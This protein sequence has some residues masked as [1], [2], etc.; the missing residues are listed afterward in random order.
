MTG[1]SSELH[2]Q[3]TREREIE[4]EIELHGMMINHLGV[5]GFLKANAHNPP[6]ALRKKD[7]RSK[8]K[9]IVMEQSKRNDTVGT[10]VRFKALFFFFFCRVFS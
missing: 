3:Q 5:D 10:P 6:T 1:V 7:L 2:K 8:P 9:N 4:R